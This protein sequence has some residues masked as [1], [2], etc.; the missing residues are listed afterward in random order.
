MSDE[1]RL[2][3]V[4]GESRSNI[5]PLPRKTSYKSS[6]EIG[7]N[8]ETSS[9]SVLQ[10]DLK[11]KVRQIQDLSTRTDE[12]N[13]FSCP[14]VFEAICCC[15]RASAHR[16]S[17]DSD[18]HSPMNKSQLTRAPLK[19]QVVVLGPSRC[20][21]T[22]L[23]LRCL[24]CDFEA[25]YEPT[26]EDVFNHKIKLPVLSFD[27]TAPVG[28][29]LSYPEEKERILHCVLKSSVPLKYLQLRFIYIVSES[30]G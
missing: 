18:T 7:I 4:L 11:R 16:E 8:S 3:Y 25:D 10:K 9:P 12:L 22:A 17:S 26:I 30:W 28:D 2:T 5:L 19:T 21:K 15:I 6:Q 29:S 24:Q 13:P 20:G 23:V 1:M 14:G 27:N